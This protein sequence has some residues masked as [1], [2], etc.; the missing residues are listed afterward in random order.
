[1]RW[2]DG[3]AWTEQTRPT[4]SASPAS[5]AAPP[6]SPSPSSRPWYKKKVWWIVGAVV[7]ILI[8]VGAVAGGGS[9]TSEPTAAKTPSEPT[10]TK[11]TTSESP[12]PK[13]TP[14]AS[15]EEKVRQALGSSVSSD[16]AIGDSKVRSANRLGTD[17]F[18]VLATPQG[19]F[20]GPSTS[21]ADA[22]ASAAFAKTYSTGWRG[23]AVVQFRGGLVDSST[24]KDLPN[25]V[26]FTY[27]MQPGKARQIDWSDQ[28]ALHS[29][30][31]SLY[32]TFCHPAFK[33]C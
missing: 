32:R 21:D 29:I 7:L 6:P 25:A 18:I 26:A 22:L 27:R 19:G 3:S 11:A 33:G 15:P 4:D 31:W 1:M 2:W 13:P 12:S 28:D 14:P 17:M 23:P 16:F 9:N 20:E 10:P 24:G 5:G 8:I 30:N